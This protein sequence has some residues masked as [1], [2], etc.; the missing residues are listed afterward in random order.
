MDQ[1]SNLRPRP[2]ALE[3]TLVQE[4]YWRHR[5]AEELGETTLL[6]DFARR[7]DEQRAASRFPFEISPELTE[8]IRRL[9]QHSP[10]AVYLV[11]TA[12][13]GVLLRKY[14]SR[15]KVVIG[16]PLY[17]FDVDA[18]QQSPLTA[19]EIGVLLEVEIDDSDDLETVLA[20]V[21]ANALEAYTHQDCSLERMA[22]LLQHEP[23]P[24]RPLFFDVLVSCETIHGQASHTQ[25]N[26][27]LVIAFQDRDETLAGEIFYDSALFVESSIQRFVGH[28]LNAARECLNRPRQPIGSLEIMGATERAQVL[29]FNHDQRPYPVDQTLTQRFELQ[30]RKTPQRTAVISNR[31]RLSYRELNA[32]A[33]RLGHRLASVIELGQFVGIL[34]QR[35]EDFLVA[36]LAVLKA[37]GAYVPI[38]PEYPDVRVRHMLSDSRVSTIM[39]ESAAVQRYQQVLAESASV[40]HLLVLD[41]LPAE[42]D[43]EGSFQCFGP[44]DWDALPDHDVPPKAMPW[45][46]MY[47]IYTSGS[48]GAPKGAMVLHRGAVNHMA[49]R[50]DTLEFDENSSFLQT[51]SSSTDISVWQFLAPLLCGGRTVIVEDSVVLDPEALLAV[52]AKQEPTLVELVPVML[53]SLLEATERRP[54]YRPGL[55]ALSFMI[56]TGDAI[57]PELVRKWFEAFPQVRLVNCYGPTEAADDVTQLILSEPLPPRQISVSIGAPLPNQYLYV[58]DRRLRLLPAGIAGEICIAGI[59]VGSGYWQNPRKTAQTFVPNPFGTGEHSVIY[60]TGDLGRWGE[61]GELEFL[62]RIDFQVKIRGFRIELGEIESVLEEHPEVRECVVIAFSDADSPKR[63]VAYVVTVDSAALPSER[64]REYLASR[65]P[66]YMMPAAYVFIDALP[67]TPNGKIDRRGLPEPELTRPD[68]SQ[69]FVAPRNTMEELLAQIWCEVLGIPQAG[70]FDNFFLLGGDSILSIKVISKL[71]QRGLKL[72]AQQLF[73]APTIADLAPQISLASAERGTSPLVA[74]RSQGSRKPLFCVHPGSGNILR[75]FNLA[76]RIRA[77]QP[78]YGLQ[79]PALYGEGSFDMPLEDKAAQYIEAIRSVEPKG[80]YHLCGWSFGGHVAFEMAQQLRRDGHTVGVL[81]ILDTRALEDMKD[82]V[83]KNDDAMLMAIIAQEWG[84]FVDPEGLRALAWDAQLERVAETLKSAGFAFVDRDWVT[85]R[86]DMFKSRI[87]VLRG[88][89]PELYPSRIILFRASQ[90]S[91]FKGLSEAEIDQTLGWGA[92]SSEEVCVHTVPGTH[93]SLGEE[94]HVRVLADHLS[95]YLSGYDGT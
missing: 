2:L 25:L 51:A 34:H 77:E 89:R 70:V 45:N 14:T 32:R 81:G 3:D 90:A 62:G 49:S 4:M 19:Q 58:A 26:H 31:G 94:P 6:P 42:C 17:R 86:L 85:W 66:D 7:V 68:M 54:E 8:K 55:E 92:L 18:S 37:G 12:V 72:S 21:R 30:V 67:L 74:I 36:I 5:L 46:P 43:L 82:Y 47:M 20:N 22:H 59:G 56:V 95:S 29:D 48:T 84:Q 75:Y 57:P 65:L 87:N 11:L 79:D 88:Y 69:P 10:L 53:R 15:R 50:L 80:P 23:T 24:G 83:E 64:L 41:G 39:T 78:V 71:D 27:D 44:S 73:Q 35:S 91:R 16:S 9:G 63:L 93:A 33:N 38:E 28:F 40:K 60:R 1:I 13:A 76:R 52:I 61:N